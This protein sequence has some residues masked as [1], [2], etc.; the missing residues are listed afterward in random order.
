MDITHIGLSSFKLRGKEATLVTDPFDTDTVG[1][2]YPKTKADIVTVSHDHSDHNAVSH[3]SDD[4]FIISGPGEYE[5]RGVSIEGFGSY[6]DDQNGE[7][8]GKNTIYHIF[9][10][11]IYILHCGD[12]GVM[13]SDEEIEAFG[14]VD[15]LMIPVGGVYTID[16]K[17]AEKLTREIGPSYVLPMHYHISQLNQKV[18]GDLAPVDEFLKE[19]GIEHPEPE[20]KLVLKAGKLSEEMQAVVFE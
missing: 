20:A 17:I 18:F 13:P 1:L 4:P 10:E 11:G 9:M 3:I 2:K 5:V 16:A 12:L 8:R 14:T 19:L 6:H 15:V 7:L